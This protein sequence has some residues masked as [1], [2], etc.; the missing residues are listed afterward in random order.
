VIPFTPGTDTT[1][2]P[3]MSK[4]QPKMGDPG[5]CAAC[6]QPIQYV[7]PYW[8]HTLTSPRHPA[9]PLGQVLATYTDRDQTPLSQETDDDA[10]DHQ[11]PDPD[12]QAQ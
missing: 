6:G 10:A 8:R 9:R 12:L 1:R 4:Q 3:E 5:V 2:R 11:T 7:G